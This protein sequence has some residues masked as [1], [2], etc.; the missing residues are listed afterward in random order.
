MH[1]HHHNMDRNA[2][3]NKMLSVLAV[4]FL[5]M[6]AEVITGY[7]SHSLSL[8]ADAGH[9]LSDAGGILLALLAIWFTTKP[10]T[11][12]KTYGYYRSEILVSFINALVL[13]IITAVILYES[14]NRFRHPEVIASG[15]VFFVALIG[16]LVNIFSLKILGSDSTSS[17]N[18]KTIYLELLSDLYATFGVILSS[19]ISYFTHWYQIDAIISALIALAILYR[20]WLLICECTHILMEGS[21][22][23]I[24]LND[25][26]KA[27]LSIPGVIDVHDIHVWTITSGLDSMSGHVLIDNQ[28]PSTEVLN[29]V[30]QVL[31]NDFHLHHTTIQVE[32]TN[33]D[34]KNEKCDSCL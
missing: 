12:G 13:V 6:L 26:H 18:V 29:K 16:V 21:P 22:G 9:M 11:A 17:L 2:S 5:Y 14:Y 15:S 20:T 30:T 8:I 1:T 24:N 19:A 27:I 28:I 4:I 3:K 31:N 34:N 7:Y 25:L 33:T 23:H 10:A 32:K